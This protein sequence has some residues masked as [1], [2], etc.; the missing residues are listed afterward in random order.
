MTQPT[1]TDS[2]S[3]AATP[4][5]NFAISEF[6]AAEC[7]WREARAAPAAQRKTAMTEGRRR[8][9]EVI[10][11][12]VGEGGPSAEVLRSARDILQTLVRLLGPESGDE[13]W[14]TQVEKNRLGK[15]LPRLLALVLDDGRF[16]LEADAADPLLT[17]ASFRQI[18]QPLELTFAPADE[19]RLQKLSQPPTR[20]SEKRGATK[21]A[22]APGKPAADSFQTDA[23][24][25]AFLQ[26]GTTESPD[27]ILVLFDRPVPQLAVVVGGTLLF[28]GDWPVA[29]DRPVTKPWTCVCWFS[30]HDGDYLELQN[31]HTPTVSVLRQLHLSRT[32][33]WLLA[34]DLLRVTGTPAESIGMLQSRWPWASPVDWQQDG[35]SREIAIRPAEGDGARVR[36]LALAMPYDR[37]FSTPDRLV[38]TAAEFT[39]ST[40]QPPS[41][42]VSQPLWT[43]LI[44]DWH[45]LRTEEPA[46]WMPLTVVEDGRIATAEE[47]RAVYWRIGTEQW[48]CYHSLRVPES[49]RSVLGLHTSH[50]TVLT[51][52]D[53]AGKHVPIVQVDATG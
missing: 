26:A 35:G 52:L 21:R 40:Q 45:P 53:R 22:A 19:A 51:R 17:A 16:L 11:A 12:V 20:R 47:A 38:N 27:R 1:P 4:R 7:V 42:P 41:A 8:L 34:C 43:P 39:I 31:N 10:A 33:C 49:P 46:D 28:Q 29:T 9:R 30:D 24:R 18:A 2:N 36:L 25:A 5:S 32:G 6:H 13:K 15:L 14:W 44:L 23:G 48:M 50:E 37:M 3:E